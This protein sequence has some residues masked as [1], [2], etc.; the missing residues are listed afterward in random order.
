MAHSDNLTP[1]EAHKATVRRIWTVTGILAALTLVEFLLAFTMTPGM[2]RNMIF[3]IMTFIKAFYIV[4]EFMHLRH[5]VKA[6]I[7]SIV[8]P[9]AFVVWLVVALLT[10]GSFIFMK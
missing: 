9:C 1:E 5:E 4:G 7:W 6:L 3:V 10:E 2:A 8:L